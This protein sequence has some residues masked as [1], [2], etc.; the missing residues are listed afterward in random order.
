MF[1]SI[2]KS[3]MSRYYGPYD[4]NSFIFR[5]LWQCFTCNQRIN[6]N[7]LYKHPKKKCYLKQIVH[8]YNVFFKKVTPILTQTN[9]IYNFPKHIRNHMIPVG[10]IGQ[11]TPKPH[12]EHRG[13]KVVSSF[14]SRKTHDSDKSPF[15]LSRP[16]TQ[17]QKCQKTAQKP[18]KALPKDAQRSPK[19]TQRH[20]KK[21]RKSSQ[22]AGQVAPKPT[23]AP[24]GCCPSPRPAVHSSK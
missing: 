10:P 22:E 3:T 1:W 14:Y 24:R 2:F 23:K 9:C 12:R 17:A 18:P 11:H 5:I 7:K 20:P 6:E 15:L 13:G 8:F 16:Q 21:L 4:V 19:A